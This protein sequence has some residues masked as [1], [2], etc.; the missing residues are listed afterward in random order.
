MIYYPLNTLMLAGIRDILVI[1]TPSDLPAFRRLLADGRDWGL[2]ISYAEQKDPRGLAEAFIIG[3]EFVKGKAVTLVLG[4]NLFHGQGLE[5]QL[6]RASAREKGATIF[7]YEVSDPSRYGVA[8]VDDSG[9][10]VGVEEKPARPKSRVAVTGIYFYDDTVA[11]IAAA[12]K[13]SQRGELEITDVNAEYLRRG[14]LSLEMLGRGMAWLDTG[15]YD[16]LH[17]AASYVRTIEARTGLKIGC[18]EETAWRAGF[19]DDAQLMRL[20]ERLGRCGYAD[21]LKSLPQ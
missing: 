3:R 1:S 5:A 18:P 19:I 12:L 14:Q 11:D 4:D 10:V 6:A 13:P 16:S 2:A 20:A 17:D 21:Y 15:T 8:E 9:K 7:G